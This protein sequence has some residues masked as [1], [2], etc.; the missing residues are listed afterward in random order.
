MGLTCSC[1][2]ISIESALEVVMC[3]H[4]LEITQL[5]QQEIFKVENFFCKLVENTIFSEKTFTDCSF[6][7]PNAAKFYEENFPEQPQN[8]KTPHSSLEH[9][10]L[11]STYQKISIN[12]LRIL[13]YTVQTAVTA[14]LILHRQPGVQSTGS[15]PPLP[16]QTQNH[17][18]NPTFPWK[19]EVHKVATRCR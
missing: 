1:L 11:Y 4:S 8:L 3:M 6:V 9:F 16:P 12:G 19:L 15:I 5:I 10:P 17:S 14:S 13:L 18:Q 7:L 2:N